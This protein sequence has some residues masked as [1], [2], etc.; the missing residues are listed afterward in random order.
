MKRYII[1]YVFHIYVKVKWVS[2]YFSWIN[3]H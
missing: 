3:E 2:Y 1:S